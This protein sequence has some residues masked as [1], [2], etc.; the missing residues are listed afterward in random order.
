MVADSRSVYWMT[1]VTGTSKSSPICSKRSTSSWPAGDEVPFEQD[2]LR[3]GEHVR[4]AMHAWFVEALEAQSTPWK[5]LRGPHEARL[6][7]A[8]DAVTSLFE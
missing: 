3:D 1:T 4:H 5:L 8:L 7:L 6:A 2:G